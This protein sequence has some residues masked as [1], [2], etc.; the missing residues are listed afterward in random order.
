MEIV[1]VG[2]N[3]FSLLCADLLSKNHKILILEINPE[4]DFQLIFRLCI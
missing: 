3:L 1:I 4:Q 2:G